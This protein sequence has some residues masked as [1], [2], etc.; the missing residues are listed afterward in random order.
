MKFIIEKK[1]D[2]LHVTLVI[3]SALDDAMLRQVFDMLLLG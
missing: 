2:G 1:D 3:N